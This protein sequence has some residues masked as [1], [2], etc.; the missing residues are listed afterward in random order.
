MIGCRKLAVHMEVSRL[1][2]ESLED[3]SEERE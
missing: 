3:R 1:G 2:D